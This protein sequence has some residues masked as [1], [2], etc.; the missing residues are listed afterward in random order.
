MQSL[1]WPR[2]A[3]TGVPDLLMVAYTTS[4]EET[5]PVWIHGEDL[6]A[7][8]LPHTN[9]QLSEEVEQLLASVLVWFE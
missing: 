9:R 6:A 2:H 8:L 4:A 3:L 5:D 7:F 1:A